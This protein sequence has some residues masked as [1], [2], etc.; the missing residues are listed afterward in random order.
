MVHARSSVG[1]SFYR[2]DAIQDGD[3]TPDGRLASVATGVVY[4]IFWS[5]SSGSGGAGTRAPNR[6]RAIGLDGAL[7]HVDN[8]LRDNILRVGLNYKLN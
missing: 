1:A 3:D 7:L 2:S 8:K 4:S 5:T 6:P